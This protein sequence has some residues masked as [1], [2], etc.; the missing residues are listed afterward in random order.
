MSLCADLNYNPSHEASYQGFYN[1]PD[2]EGVGPTLKRHAQWLTEAGV[3][4]VIVG[5]PFN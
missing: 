2:C 4:H 1:Q 3:D 5:S